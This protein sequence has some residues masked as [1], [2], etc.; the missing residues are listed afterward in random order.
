MPI[1]RTSTTIVI[2]HGSSPRIDSP[3]KAQPRERLVGDR[4][5]Q[6]A[7]IGDDLVAASEIQPSM[8]SVAIG[9]DEHH[10]R[11]PAQRRRPA[12]PSYQ[13]HPQ[14]TPART[15][16]ATIVMAL[17]S[18]RGI[19]HLSPDPSGPRH[20]H[21]SSAARPRGYPSNCASTGSAWRRAGIPTARQLVVSAG[22]SRAQARQDTP[23]SCSGSDEHIPR[24]RPLR[25]PDDLA[26]FE[27]VHEASGFGEADAQFALQHRRR[28]ELGRH[29]QLGGREQQFEIVADVGVD[30]LLLRLA[31]ATS[32]R[33]SG[34]ACAGDVGFTTF[35]ISASLTPTLPAP[36]AT[37]RCP[38]EGTGASPC[39][40]RRSAP[41]WSRMTRRV[42]DTGHGEGQP[43]RGHWP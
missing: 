19:G 32:W 2:H 6:L 34:R 21:Q 11:R 13:Q 33:Y 14:G 42:G 27:Q 31:T 7:E 38:W 39:P 25:R 10:R 12:P 9:D 5:E 8:P 43:G 35:S 40:M 28:P 20:P 24:L 22:G 4:V 3:T 1:S 30:L 26:R 15:E 16:C 36:A 18:C 41:G 29:D 17:G 37:S 23:G